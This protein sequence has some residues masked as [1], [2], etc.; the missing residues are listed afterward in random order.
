MLSAGLSAALVLMRRS[1]PDIVIGFGGYPTL[2]PMFAARLLRIPTLIHEQNAV[3]GRA[4]RVLTR[5]VRGIGLSFEPTK[6]VEGKAR[7]KARLTGAPVRAEVL[8]WAEQPYRAPGPGQRLNFLIFGGSQGARY[9]SEIAPRALR[10]LPESMRQRLTVTQQCREEDIAQVRAAYEQIGVNAQLATFFKDMPERMAAAHLVLSRAGAST[11]AE[12][13]AMGRPSIL[14]PLPHALDNDQLEN[15]TRAE[16]AGGAWCIPQKELTP[17]R[18]TAELV[19][20]LEA[21][22]RL[23]EAAVRVKRLARIDAV[24]RLAEFADELMA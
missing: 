20:L 18:L 9:F 14:V 1:R 16:A 19:L 11:V 7:S 21:P 15:A 23:S 8:D 22:E 10:L 17:E 24:S 12:L 5:I 4:N 13:A 2:P 3:M 6:F